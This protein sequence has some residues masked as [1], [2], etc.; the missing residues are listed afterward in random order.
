M[1]KTVRSLGGIAAATLLPFLLIQAGCDSGTTPP[2]TKAAKILS[3]TTSKASVASGEKVTL[4]WST[5]NATS[6]KIVATPGGN[7]I[8]GSTMASGSVDS[9]A[10][11]APTTF[12]LTAT[13]DGGNAMSSQMVT[14]TSAGQV[15]I[16]T[17]TATPETIAAGGSSLLAWDTENATSV[18]IDELNGGNIVPMGTMLSG[19]TTV[20]PT[21]T[22]TYV[23]TAVGSSGTVTDMKTVTVEGTPVITSFAAN[24]QAIEL[25]ATSTLS[26][27]V[28]GASQITVVDEQANPIYAGTNLNGTVVVTPTM[29]RTYH[30]TA[31]STLGQSVDSNN[32]TVTVNRA[33]KILSFGANPSTIPYGST[34]ALEWS[35]DRSTSIDIMRAGTTIHTN[36]AATGSF[37][38]TAT[39]TTEYV[40]VAH[41]VDG[42]ST[43]MTTLTVSSVAP[44]VTSFAFDAAVVRVGAVDNLNWAVVG[45]ANVVVTGPTG[46]ELANTANNTGSVPVTVTATGTYTLVATNPNGSTQATAT[47]TALNDP[48]IGTFTVV[49]LSYTQSSTSVRVTW[50]TTLARST[51]LTIDGV[52][53]AGFAGTATGTY[54]FTSSTSPRLVFTARNA[55]TTTVRQIRVV[56]LQVVTDTGTT[57]ATAGALAGDGTG[58]SAQIQPAAD[59]DFY[60]IVVPANG[61]VTLETSNGQGGCNFDT[62]IDLI[63]PDGTTVLGTDDDDGINNCSQIDPH[64]DAFAANLPAGTYYVR[65]RAFSSSATFNYVLIATAAAPACANSI[66]ESGAGEQCDDGNTAVGDGCSATCTAD[67]MATMNGPGNTASFA[68]SIVVA[69]RSN[70][71]QVVMQ[72]PGY[73]AAETFMPSIGRCDA[74]TGSADTVL[75]LLDSNFAPLGSDDNDGLNSCS[76][77]D[78]TVDTFAAV[79]AGT[80]YLRVNEAGND[81]VIGAYVVEIRTI[82]Q[83]CPNGVLEVGEECDDGNNRGGDGCSVLC[84]FE[85]LTEVEPNNTF[86]TGTIT[87]TAAGTFVVRGSLIANDVDFFWVDVP[88]GHHL[89]AYATLNSLDACPETPELEVGLFSTAGTSLTSNTTGGPQGNCGRI[90]PYTTASARGMAVG[91]YG[92]RIR[93]GTPATPAGNYFLHIRVIAPGCGNTIIEGTEQCEDGNTASGDGCTA[94]CAFEA[95]QT[96]DLSTPVTATVAGLIDPEYNRDAYQLVVSTSTVHLFAT[97]YVDAATHTCPT[98]DTSL[99]LYDST[100]NLLGTDNDSGP[101]LCSA[102]N[103]NLYTFGTLGPGTYWL[104]VESSNN[105]TRAGAYSLVLQS[106]AAGICGNGI[107]DQT[108]EQC[109]GGSFCDAQCHIVPVGVVNGPPASVTLNDSIVPALDLHFFRVVASAD[110]YILVE[111]G[112]PTIGVCPNDDTQVSIFDETTGQELAFND[113]SGPGFCSLIN[114]TTTDPAPRVAAGNYLVR[115]NSYVDFSGAA[116]P[117]PAYQIKIDVVA[118]DVCGNGF[119]EAGEQCDDTNTAGGDGCSPT[120]QSE[121]AIVPE[122]EPNDLPTTAQNLGTISGPTVIDV[123]GALTPNADR[124]FFTFTVQGTVQ[125]RINTY[126]TANQV[127]TS[128]SGDTELWLYNAVPAD[129]DEIDSTFEPTILGYSDD[130]GNGACSIISGT[131]SS[132]STVTLTAGTYIVQARR[133]NNSGS[134]ANYFVNFTFQ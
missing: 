134:I 106:V 36:P 73:I 50:A 33:A 61:N 103:P 4:S 130:E 29:N 6:I 43:A 121:T 17:F 56:K 22:K 109:D 94:A 28:T 126:G 107:V 112:A 10:I 115:V 120:C 82:G 44:V 24:P 5:E 26:W 86:A 16:K 85:G 88:A 49:P 18:K 8:E 92:I 110:A 53:A 83:G 63:G 67:I 96:I 41:N 98:A 97:T 102:I 131:D 34:A 123:Q 57:A 80:Y 7:V 12:V 105:R 13:G 60:S 69:G 84:T 118:A 79:P 99:R 31:R 124:D 66:L 117:I 74:A 11:T 122:T 71:I 108:S 39:R 19:S 114:A 100:G 64:R 55:A 95:L 25:G 58:V 68:G 78:P 111:T 101:G 116:D 46:T 127:L 9:M 87:A 119:V 45:A 90:W 129:I 20:M 47:V 35:V 72:A 30:L 38:V 81:A 52:A 2:V 91:R 93:S 15:R 51:E 27:S 62:L 37:S 77:I 75:T 1:S 76:R 48:I 132:P 23:I 54:S 104:V 113:D 133:Y 42:D 3:F 32:V 128:C 65:V 21:T 59:V 14:I 70:F 125:A 89:D 40:L